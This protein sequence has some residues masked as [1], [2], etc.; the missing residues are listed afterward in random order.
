MLI[1]VAARDELYADGRRMNEYKHRKNADE[2][3]V[4]KGTRNLFDS[5][6]NKRI[7]E[8]RHFR[9]GGKYFWR[10]CLLGQKHEHG[11]LVLRLHDRLAAQ[12]EKSETGRKSQGA[13]RPLCCCSRYY[14]IPEQH[15]RMVAREGN[16][17]DDVGEAAAQRISSSDW[18]AEGS[19]ANS[20]GSSRRRS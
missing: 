20:G 9:G 2:Q 10:H 8:I 13:V 14:N 7:S 19:F 18:R 15:G 4:Q 3:E 12:A 1:E 6:R 16:A 11:V 5:P 17:V